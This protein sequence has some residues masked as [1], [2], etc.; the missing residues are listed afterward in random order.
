MLVLLETRAT[1]D[2]SVI[3]IAACMSASLALG[4]GTLNAFL[5]LAFPAWERVWT[6]ATRPL[7]IISG[8][9]FLFED[10]P[11]DLARFLWFNPLFH[12]TGQMRSGFY[13]IYD[14]TYVSAGFT[15]GIGIGTFLLGLLL[16]ARHGDGIIHK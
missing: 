11:A 12:V 13:A 14:A 2:M 8:V 7:F 9:F 5:F 3:L 4:I 16:L 10:L 15:F 1:P 6:I